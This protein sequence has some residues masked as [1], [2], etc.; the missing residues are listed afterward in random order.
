MGIPSGVFS[1]CFHS[2]YLFSF[3]CLV[4]L[5]I[6]N[7]DSVCLP[8]SF[9]HLKSNCLDGYEEKCQPIYRISSDTC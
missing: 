2:F 6:F 1:F 3:F 4:R 8:G 9:M 5:L 7:S